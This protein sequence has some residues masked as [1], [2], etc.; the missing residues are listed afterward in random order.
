MFLAAVKSTL[1]RRGGGAVGRSAQR[2]TAI[3]RASVAARPNGIA[4]AGDSP[5]CG[6]VGGGAMAGME[7]G[8]C[9]H[10][11]EGTVMQKTKPEVS[12]AAGGP[13]SAASPPADGS[14]EVDAAG[15]TMAQNLLWQMESLPLPQIPP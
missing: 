10:S 13:L 6:S 3:A 15:A 5:R 2:S 1:V 4:Q 12:R 9:H 11:S 14:A 8:P 7:A